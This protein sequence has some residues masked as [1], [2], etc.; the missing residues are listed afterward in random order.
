MSERKGIGEDR[1]GEDRIRLLCERS[2]RN[3][4][5]MHPIKE[6]KYDIEE[7]FVY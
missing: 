2:I 1:R 4:P 3:M 6:E 5:S 7:S